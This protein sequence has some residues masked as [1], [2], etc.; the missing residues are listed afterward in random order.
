MEMAKGGEL[1]EYIQ[2]H[3][4]TEEDVKLFF[5]QII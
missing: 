3:R 2:K 4:L 1:Y 5:R